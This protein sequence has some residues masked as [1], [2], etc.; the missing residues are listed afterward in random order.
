MKRI[1]L[2]LA[3]RCAGR[4]ALVRR[5]PSGEIGDHRRREHHYRGRIGKATGA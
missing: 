4:R 5:T 2:I 1:L 3:Q